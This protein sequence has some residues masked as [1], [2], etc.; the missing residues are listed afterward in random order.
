MCTLSARVCRNAVAFA[1][2]WAHTAERSAAQS[3]ST[4]QRSAAQHS[5]GTSMHHS[6]RAWYV[7]WA[8]IEGEGCTVQGCQLGARI[9]TVPFYVYAN[10][11]A[12][13]YTVQHRCLQM[14][15]SGSGTSH[16]AQDPVL[17]H[18][19]MQVAGIA[20]E[21]STLGLPGMPQRES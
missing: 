2:S 12:I 16:P 15:I 1:D 4:A 8:R 3:R 9:C 21:T 7:R 5:D 10:A 18:G 13:G 11:H 20:A 17:I 14:S 19:C 6:P